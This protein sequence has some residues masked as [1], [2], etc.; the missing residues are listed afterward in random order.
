MEDGKLLEWKTIDSRRNVMLSKSDWT[1]LQDAGL[2]RRCVIEWR[3]WR[4]E[5]RSVQ[6]DSYDNR[7][8]AT[9]E[10][11]RLRDHQ[12]KLEYSPDEEVAWEQDGAIIS[13]LDL[14][15]R[16]KEIILEINMTSQPPQTPSGAALLDSVTDIGIARQ[17]ARKL[18]RERYLIVIGSASPAHELQFMYHERLSQAIDLLSDTSDV[19]PLLEVMASE[20]DKTPQQVAESVID[21]HRQ[22]INVFCSVEAGYLCA[23]KDIQ[24]SDIIDELKEIVTEYGH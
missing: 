21:K 18:V 17:I 3:S 11:R 20:L 14:T 1:Q 5:L 4:K 9:T 19:V 12:P 15:N 2:S 6:F 22:L 8:D 13:R 24:D 23:L 10:I 7:I 16:I